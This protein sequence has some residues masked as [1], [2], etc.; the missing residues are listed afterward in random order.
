LNVAREQHRL[1]HRLGGRTLADERALAVGEGDLQAGDA[2]ARGRALDLGADLG[3]RVLGFRRR[4]K[5]F[6]ADVFHEVEQAHR[7]VSFRV[8]E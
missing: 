4:G 6:L 2:E 7:E 3:R 5:E 8:G 1:L